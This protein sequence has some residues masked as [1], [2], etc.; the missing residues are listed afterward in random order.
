MHTLKTT[1]QVDGV[2]LRVYS[3]DPVTLDL[4]CVPINGTVFRHLGPETLVPDQR[5][6]QIDSVC[7]S[8]VARY[9]IVVEYNTFTAAINWLLDSVSESKSQRKKITKC[10]KKQ[11]A[12]SASF[13]TQGRCLYGIIFFY[14]C[15]F[16][17][18]LVFQQLAHSIVPRVPRSSVTS[19]SLAFLVKLQTPQV[20]SAKVSPSL[21][22]PN[23]LG[24]CLVGISY[25]KLLYYCCL[26][27]KYVVKLE[28]ISMSCSW[29]L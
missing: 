19:S 18:T 23:S 16:S 13:W 11:L 10:H 28:Q 9:E 3:L 29:M 21:S 2:T 17:Q 5:H 7:L 22:P 20:P 12:Q 15:S 6:H 8:S 4:N 26:P 14:S 27:A 1:T 24:R 25:I